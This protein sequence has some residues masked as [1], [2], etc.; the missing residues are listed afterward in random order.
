MRQIVTVTATVIAAVSLIAAGFTLAQ[1]N[2]EQLDLTARMQSR[3]QLLAD[4]LS[5][6]ISPSFRS[7]ATSSVQSTIDKFATEERI[8]GIG[9]YDTNVAPVAVSSNMPQEAASAPLL[10]TVMDENRPSGDF[11]SSRGQSIY[12]FAEPIMSGE[13]VIGVLVVAQNAQYIQDRI[14]IIWR[15]NLIRLLLQLVI[16]AGSIFV[17]VRWVFFRPLVRLAESIKSVRAGQSAET[18][19]S[20]HAFLAPLTSEL[21]KMTSS[22][23][24]ARTAASEEARLRLEKEDAPWTAERLREFVKSSMKGR[25]IYVVSNRGSHTVRRTKAGVEYVPPANG[26]TTAVTPIVET[27]GGVWFACGSVHDKDVAGKDGR[28][29]M[30]PNEEPKYTLKQILLGDEEADGHYGFSAEALYPLCLITHTRPTFKEDQWAAYKKVNGIFAQ[31]I[32]EEIA[33]VEQPII[34]IQDYHFALLPRMI[35]KSRP[36]ARIGLFWH[37]PWPNEESFSICPWRKEI[38]YGMLGADV[39]G[40][41]TRQF[42]NHF[43]DTVSSEVESLIDWEQ[44][45]VIRS[46]HRTYVMPFGIS[47]P[48]TDGRGVAGDKNATESVLRKLRIN[49][50]HVA[51][52]VD[53]LDYAK[54]LPERFRSIEYFL[55]S[56]PEYLGNFTLLQ[57]ASP[58]RERIP[59]YQKYKQQVVFEAQRIN[60]KFATKD[61]RPIVLELRQYSHAELSVL[62]ERADICLVTSLHD[63]MNLVAK[64][65]VAAQVDGHG[66]LVI[67][68][69]AGASREL[70]GALVVNP[71]SAKETADAI[72]AGL[73]MPMSD[74]YRRMKLMRSIIKR[75]NVY[76]WGGDFIRAVTELG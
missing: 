23:R 57:I 75:Y 67:S 6:S 36:D 27:C 3:T 74:R 11:V 29:P 21:S 71:Y 50:S 25:S 4:S 24:Q 5:E 58:H 8:A 30:P 64:E 65:Y 44:F 15:D 33:A 60:K 69:F 72:H 7:Y 56:H 18:G 70:R 48:F 40:F 9:V 46:G 41:N 14:G 49:S 28:L 53:R 20:A 12:V 34:L 32:L 13:H 45:S 35:K 26:M 51:L 39:I 37:V 66:V 76:R 31:Q 22:L 10:P 47:I 19:G 68:Q 38:L 42:C 54:G 16:V 55:E 1:A 73:T 52:G 2:Q 62:Y 61:W 17:L 63:S 43:M 59:E